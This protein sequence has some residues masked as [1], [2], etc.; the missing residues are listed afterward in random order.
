MRPYCHN[1]A[2][3]AIALCIGALLLTDIAIAQDAPD[4][5]P[6]TGASAAATSTANDYILQLDELRAMGQLQA[7]GTKENVAGASAYEFSSH[8]QR[9]N[10]MAAGIRQPTASDYTTALD[11]LRSMAPSNHR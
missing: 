7:M 6:K 4:T 2:R 3:T 1:A 9:L 5:L 10:D 11:Q 8:L